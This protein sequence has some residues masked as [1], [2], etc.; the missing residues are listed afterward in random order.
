MFIRLLKRTI[1]RVLEISITSSILL[2]FVFFLDTKTNISDYLIIILSVILIFILSFII[3]LIE[4]KIRF[5]KK[6]ED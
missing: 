1:K 5:K 4:G 6:K 2:L 3:L